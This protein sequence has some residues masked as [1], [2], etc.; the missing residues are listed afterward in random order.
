MEL[1]LNLR[2]CL[3]TELEMRMPFLL[4]EAA[5]E[6]QIESLGYSKCILLN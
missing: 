3:M 1:M 6:S 4:L 5:S 2:K